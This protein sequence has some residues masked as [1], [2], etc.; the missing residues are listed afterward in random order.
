V[1]LIADDLG[2]LFI[3]APHTGC[4]AV[5]KVLVDQFGARFVP[6]QD[7][8]GADGQVTVPRKHTLLSQLTEAGLLTS[9][10]RAQLTVASGIRNPFDLLVSA[11]MGAGVYQ[12]DLASGK[13]RP[14]GM[15]A[16][17]VEPS[18]DPAAFE[19]W[20]RT[21]FGRPLSSRL[22]GQR[23]REPADFAA[24]ADVVLRFE[25]LQD[26]FGA[27]MTQLGVGDPPEIPNVNPT[28]RREHRP[29]QSFYT[30]A[31]VEIVGEIYARQLARDGYTF[32]SLPDQASAAASA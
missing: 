17:G 26:D 1:A 18:T 30:P 10:A 23:W 6:E 12:K 16:P 27:L 13:R 3:M 25:R 20:L 29:Y 7:V 31:A 2:L 5:G 11:F 8:V 24:G 22:R 19:A 32:D 9:E 28:R 21:R 15:A 14:P 4:T